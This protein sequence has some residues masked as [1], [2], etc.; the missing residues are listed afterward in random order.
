MGRGA[1]PAGTR[2]HTHRVWGKAL[3]LLP[4]RVRARVRI[5]FKN[6]GM[7]MGIVVPYPLG[8]HCHP[9]HSFSFLLQIS[10]PRLTLFHLPP[11]TLVP[12]PF[13]TTTTSPSNPHTNMNHHFPT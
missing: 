11:Q 3:K 4:T 2:T 7:G 8:T 6:A 1:S 9:T 5:I 13:L 12:P 10:L